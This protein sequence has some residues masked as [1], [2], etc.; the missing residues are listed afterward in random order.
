MALE[1]IVAD[2]E[3]HVTYSYLTIKIILRYSSEQVLKII[4]NKII[5]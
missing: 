2:L 1:H 4:I 3:I 5:Y